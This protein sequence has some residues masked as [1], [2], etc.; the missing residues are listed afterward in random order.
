M[1][2]MKVA[3]KSTRSKVVRINTRFPEAT[4]KRLREASALRGQSVASFI[5]D[6]ASRE[7]DRVLEQEKQW[8]LSTRA[9]ETMQQLL[10]K[11][12]LI[13]AAAK[14]AAKDLAKHVRIR[15]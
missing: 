1:S 10:A 6:A 14:K 7:A 4:V 2:L 12:P 11:P 9:A 13:N 3:P 5:L 8:Q 15:S